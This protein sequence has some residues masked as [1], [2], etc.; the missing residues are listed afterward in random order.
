MVHSK[1]PVII[2][3]IYRPPKPNNVFIQEFAKLLSHFTSKYDKIFIL[4]NFNIHICCPPQMFVTDFMDTLESFNLTQAIQEPTHS[5]GQTLDLVLYSGLT[6]TILRLRISVCLITK[7]FYSVWLYPNY[8]LI[9]V[10]P[11]AAMFFIQCL[12]ASFL[13]FYCCFFNCL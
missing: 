11:S 13:S 6:P 9:T 8:L 12:L 1:D 5:K 10:Y 3:I 4:G 7:Q 2:L